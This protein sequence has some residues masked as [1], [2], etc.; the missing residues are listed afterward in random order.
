VIRK[1][2][3]AIF[4][5]TA[6]VLLSA[7]VAPTTLRPSYSQREFIT[8]QKRQAKAAK[9]VSK[10]FDAKQTYSK[11]RI[12]KMSARLDK[13]ST[14]IENASRGLCLALTSGDAKCR[15]EVIL[16]PDKKGLNAHADGKNVVVYP[17]MIDFATNDNQ[18]AFVIAHEFAHNILSH[19]KALMT[20]VAA[21]GIL[22]SLVDALASSQGMNTGGAFGKIGAQQ[23]QL[24]YSP[25]FEHEADY[26]GLYILARAGFDYKQ[27]PAF[28]RVMSVANPDSIYLTTT[29]PTNPSRTI[30]MEKTVQEI[31]Y[32]I[33]HK[34]PLLPNF[35]QQ[36]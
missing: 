5:C 34:I 14:P 17:A 13:A 2:S 28:W 7:C 32:K 24:S 31:D 10:V 22:G 3:A 25:D 30:E 12:K 6:L 23:G 20:N 16:A 4:A 36:T 8:E 15:F 27:A 1:F 26:V 9:A 11:T 21:G 29:H 35:L 18:L 19:Q 33:G